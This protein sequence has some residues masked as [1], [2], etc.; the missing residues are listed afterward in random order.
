MRKV[1]VPSGF[2]TTLS[3]KEHQEALQHKPLKTSFQ[4]DL[5]A[6]GEI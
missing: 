3:L 5:S 2:Q 1:I 6:R 4:S